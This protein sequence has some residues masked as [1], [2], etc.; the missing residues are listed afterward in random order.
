MTL[1][2]LHLFGVI[3]T[4][5]MIV[6]DKVTDAVP[7][8]EMYVPYNGGDPDLFGDEGL[9]DHNN[10]L[11]QHL[12]LLTASSNEKTP[13]FIFAHSN[14][15][16]VSAGQIS[17][18][19]RDIISGAGYSIIS[20]ESVSNI[21][22]QETVQVCWSDFDLVWEWFQSNAKKYNFDTTSVIIGGRSRG[23][24]CSWPLAYSKK[25]EINGIYMYNALP[26]PWEIGN[27]GKPWVHDVT[28][29]S[30]SAYLVYGPECEK[31]IKQDC[32]PS[33]DMTDIHNPRNGQTIVDRYTE[34]GMASMITL[35][36]GLKNHEEG[37]FD[38]FPSYVGFITANPTITPASNSSP[39]SICVN[40]PD[41]YKGKKHITCRWIIT[42]ENRQKKWCKEEDVLYACP[43]TCGLC[44]A[45]ND[46]VQ[47]K[48]EICEWLREKPRRV[49][50]YCQ[51]MRVKAEC[52]KTCDNY[53]ENQNS[54]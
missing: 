18:K 5:M 11:R 53:Q 27:T 47:Y 38:Y 52:V 44:F 33:P 12:H 43:V 45:D 10:P 36:D 46:T 32:E 35:T 51:N 1:H 7:W 8:T 54:S 29:K 49:K 16:K 6:A 30:P 3:I 50:K 31:P 48:K 15:K 22:S 23:S 21:S 14:G 24:I 37:V 42:R 34:L 26:N 20:W 19:D 17:G 39:K 40:D 41:F 9:Y 25:A 2:Y 4:A 13:V 28:L